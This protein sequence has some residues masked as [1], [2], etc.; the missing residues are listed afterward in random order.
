MLALCRDEEHAAKVARAV[1]PGFARV[2]I[3]RGPVPGV[4]FG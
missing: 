3:A 4:T 2:E 1:R